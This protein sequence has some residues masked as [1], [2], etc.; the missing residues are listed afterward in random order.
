MRSRLLRRRRMR[1]SSCRE[2]TPMSSSATLPTISF[3][4]RWANKLAPAGMA[5]LRARPT[6][7]EGD[8]RRT[9]SG[10]PELVPRP[11]LCRRRTR[12]RP[13]RA[14]GLPS[15]LCAPRAP[16]QHFYWR[17]ARGASSCAGRKRQQPPQAICAGC[18]PAQWRYQAASSQRGARQAEMYG[19]AARL[20]KAGCVVVQQCVKLG[21]ERAALN[22]HWREEA[23]SVCQVFVFFYVLVLYVCECTRT[24]Y[25][26]TLHT[27]HRKPKF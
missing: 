18:G 5:R 9:R 8:P 26:T 11:S 4:S 17:A 16:T 19:G 7:H 12:T 3:A 21:C 20:T 27:T 24:A 14:R 10:D 13:E 15:E 1:C 2:S 23:C 25:S 6:C 22:E